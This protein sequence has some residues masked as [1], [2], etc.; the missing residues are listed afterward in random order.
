MWL[1]KNVQVWFW[2]WDPSQT[3]NSCADGVRLFAIDSTVIY[4]WLRILE[5]FVFWGL[6]YV[7]LNNCVEVVRQ[8]MMALYIIIY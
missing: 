5:W 1:H 4:I 6:F 2:I 7:E 3:P 8:K